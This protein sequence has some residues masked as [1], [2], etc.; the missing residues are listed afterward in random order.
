MQDNFYSM[1]Q[2]VQYLRQYVYYETQRRTFVGRK[3]STRVN[4]ILSVVF[5]EGNTVHGTFVVTSPS[6]WSDI[7]TI[8]CVVLS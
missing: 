7:M 4:C 2:R 1:K 8:T 3:V 6:L 5:Y